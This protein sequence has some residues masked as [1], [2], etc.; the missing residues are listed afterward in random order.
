MERGGD[1]HGA[2]HQICDDAR[3]RAAHLL[4]ELEIRAPSVTRIRL[5]PAEMHTVVRLVVRHAYPHAHCGMTVPHDEVPRRR[6][7]LHVVCTLGARGRED[8]E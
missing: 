3:E 2:R 6:N 5:V 7:D 4:V 1:T 8:E